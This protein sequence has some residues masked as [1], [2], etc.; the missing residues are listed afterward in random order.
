MK[1]D[2]KQLS[3]SAGYKSLKAA[4]I[5]DVQ[6][7]AKK[8]NPMRKKEEFLKL[9]RWVMARAQHYAVRQ[10]CSVEVVL[11][12]WEAN[13][14]YWWLNYYQEGKKPKL[15][16]GKSRNVQP[17]KATTY[18]RKQYTGRMYTRADLLNRL[19]DLRNLEARRFRQHVLKKKARWPIDR[20]AR[21]ARIRTYKQE[22]NL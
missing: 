11:N 1:I 8:K 4:Y 3:Q 10:G 18:Y 6:E 19:R 17:Q 12:T 14:D 7:A 13:R 15:P 9:F 16:S 5:R 20:K 21:A 2:W 22:R